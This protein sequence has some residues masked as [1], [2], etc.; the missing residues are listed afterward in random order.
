MSYLNV[1]P[2]HAI[3]SSR[4]A[5]NCMQKKKWHNNQMLIVMIGWT[6]RVPYLSIRDGFGLLLKTLNYYVD[7][8]QRVT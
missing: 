5:I 8:N 2:Y 3:V 7:W 4:Q 1:Q 6:F